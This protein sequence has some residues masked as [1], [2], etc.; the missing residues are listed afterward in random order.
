MKKPTVKQSD[1]LIKPAKI[2]KRSLIVLA[3]AAVV[4]IAALFCLYSEDILNG[5]GD[6]FSIEGDELM[7]FEKATVKEILSEDLELDEVADN[8]Y[9]GSQ[10][11][12]VRVLSGR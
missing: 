8:A 4:F 7:E 2:D 6:I 1:I 10:E 9:K 5:A 3:A 11:L 12:S